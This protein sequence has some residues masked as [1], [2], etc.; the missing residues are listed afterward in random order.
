MSPASE[1]EMF[2][3][4]EQIFSM[5]AT[6]E[7]I[8]IINCKVKTHVITGAGCTPLS[9]MSRTQLGKPALDGKIKHL[10][11]YDSHQF[12]LLNHLLVTLSETEASTHKNN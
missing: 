8:S 4:K 11:A 7:Y 3:T 1:M 10:E 2:Y 6:W 5:S 12:S 9:S